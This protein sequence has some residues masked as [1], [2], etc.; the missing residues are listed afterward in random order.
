MSRG[1]P[2]FGNETVSTL[3]TNLCKLHHFFSGLCPQYPRVVKHLGKE[4][5]CA[6]QSLEFELK[7]AIIEW[8]ERYP[9]VQ[10]VIKQAPSPYLYEITP[11][12]PFTGMPNA[13]PRN[14]SYRRSSATTWTLSDFS[15]D[16]MEVITTFI[17]HV[18]NYE[19]QSK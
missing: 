8:P 10:T 4:Y 9:L 1:A 6:L 17:K 7:M 3:T 12:S 15:S 18:E 2:H 19:L 5:H 14:F 16:R 13:Q 11:I